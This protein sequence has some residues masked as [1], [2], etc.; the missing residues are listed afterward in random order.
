MVIAA[1]QKNVTT[2][3]VPDV[4]AV[5][6]VGITC[7]RKS[8]V[9]REIERGLRQFKNGSGSDF[10]FAISLWSCVQIWCQKCDFTEPNMD[11]TV[12]SLNTVEI[13]P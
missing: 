6:T 12:K 3:V 7:S 2:L 5:L 10:L 1:L 9:P 13:N 8:L 11:A 4:A